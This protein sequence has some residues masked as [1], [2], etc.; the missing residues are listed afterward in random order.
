M[1]KLKN[2]FFVQYNKL[3]RYSIVPCY[4]NVQDDKYMMGTT[5][6]LDKKTPY[7]IHKVSSGDTYDTLALK[8]YDNPT[9]YWIIC[10]FNDVQNS[11]VDPLIGTELKIPIVSHINFDN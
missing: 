11:L 6:H 4:Y 8:Y 9:L 5:Y 3:S 1:E 2:K 10:E 7:K